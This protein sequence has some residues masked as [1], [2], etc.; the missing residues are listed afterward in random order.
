MRVGGQW[1]CMNVYR[2]VNYHVRGNNANKYKYFQ[3]YLEDAIGCRLPWMTKLPSNSNATCQTKAEYEAYMTTFDSLVSLSENTISRMTGCKPSCT[4]NE[5]T[6]RLMSNTHEVKEEGDK[7]AE[8]TMMHIF[9][10]PSGRYVGK[11][12]YYTYNANAFFADIGGYLGLLLGHSVL[13]FYDI[14]KRTVTRLT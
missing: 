5:Y 4:R 7:I 1:I 12:F 10:F 2:Q 13:S 14:A 6:R 9:Y 11:K 8:R 3:R